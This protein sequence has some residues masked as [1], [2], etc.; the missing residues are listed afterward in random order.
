MVLKCCKVFV[1][2][3]SRRLKP[4]GLNSDLTSRAPL[5]ECLS[6]H[7]KGFLMVSYQ[8]GP[9]MPGLGQELMGNVRLRPNYLRPATFKIL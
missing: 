3:R 4:V 8:L 6:P 2:D 9:D 7:K 1:L 5:A